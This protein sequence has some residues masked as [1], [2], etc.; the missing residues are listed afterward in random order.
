MYVREFNIIAI[1]KRVR[2]R[3]YNIIGIPA[4][5]VII[6]PH[7]IQRFAVRTL[8]VHMNLFTI[9]STLFRV[10]VSTLYLNV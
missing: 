4:Y 10:R 7:T 1:I 9:F 8:R 6:L 3:F 5:R 2:C